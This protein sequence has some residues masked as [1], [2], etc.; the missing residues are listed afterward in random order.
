VPQGVYEL[1]ELVDFGIRLEDIVACQLLDR[2]NRPYSLAA[3]QLLYCQGPLRSPAKP[4]V[5]TLSSHTVTFSCSNPATSIVASL[6]P[7]NNPPPAGL[8]CRDRPGP[9]SKVR[10]FRSLI[11]ARGARQA[12]ETTTRA[13][14][15]LIGLALL[16]AAEAHVLLGAQAACESAAPR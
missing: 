14:E 7:R 2:P 11:G 3:C 1:D 4:R 6:K 8:I 12:A 5:G 16:H 10:R 9:Y 15:V 13:S